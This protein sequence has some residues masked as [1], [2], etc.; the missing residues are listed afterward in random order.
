MADFK[1]N[2]FS[3]GQEMP[4][5]LEKLSSVFTP[6]KLA[7]SC[8]PVNDIINSGRRHGFIAVSYGSLRCISVN[9]RSIDVNFF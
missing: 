4:I 8:K 9:V 2:F 7:I 3:D 5:C 6:L 1:M